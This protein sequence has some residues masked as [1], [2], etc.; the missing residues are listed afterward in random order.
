MSLV[1][2]GEVLLVL[3]IVVPVGCRYELRAGLRS[4]EV[5]PRERLVETAL[6]AVDGGVGVAV[7]L[8]VGLRQGML[9]A[10]RQ[11]RPQ[12]QVR[13]GVGV[14]E[15]VADHQLRA[16]VDPQHLFLQDDAAHAVGDRR[17]GRILE[18]GDV[19]VAARLVDPLETM[20]R[21]VEALVVLHDRLVER[22]Q[23][24]AGAVAVV[25]G[26]HDQTMV[27]ARIAADDGGAHVAADAVGGEHLPLE[28]ILQVA[29]F[30]FVEG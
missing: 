2:A 23:Q 13:L 25:D 29:Q 30:A 27:A 6:H 17:G 1:A 11:E 20:Q 18:V 9:V 24:Q 3:E 4:L 21:Q 16:L 14:D 22:R 26:C 15:R 7:G 28:R 8:H 12:P 5:E 19:F 10:E